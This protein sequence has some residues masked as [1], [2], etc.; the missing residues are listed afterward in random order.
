ML[1]TDPAHAVREREKEISN[2]RSGA[3]QELMARWTS[4]RC[5][6]NCSGVIQ[7]G[8]TIRNDIQRPAPLRRHPTS[9]ERPA[10]IGEST[11]FNDS[12]LMVTPPPLVEAVSSASNASLPAKGRSAQPDLPGEVAAG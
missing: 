3:T 10:N 9:R 2:D 4:A 5:A 6:A 8:R 1:K 11:I 7:E 12:G